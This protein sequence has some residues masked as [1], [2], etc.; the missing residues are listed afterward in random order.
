MSASRLLL[1]LFLSSL[2][3][4]ASCVRSGKTPGTSD[5]TAVKDSSLSGGAKLE[6]T[7]EL[8]R[9]A[10]HGNKGDSFAY[11]LT[12]FQDVT[13]TRDSSVEK[14]RQRMAYRYR[15]DVLETSD[16]G[17]SRLRVTCLGMKFKGEYSSNGES[18]TMQYDSGEKNDPAKDKQ[19]AQY[20]APVNAP[21]EIQLSKEGKIETVSKYEEVIKRL[22]GKE[23]NTIKQEA[24]QKI[25]NDFAE[26]GLKDIVQTAFQK[27]EDRP[28]G[29]DSAWHHLWAGDLGFMK[30][31]NDA[32]YTL[33]GFSKG[34][35]G[36][37]AHISAVMTSKY[38]GSKTLDTGQGMA[39][40]EDFDVKGSGATV[41]D[42]EKGRPDS[43]TLPQT[44][45][46]RFFIDPPA[47][48]K[49]AAPDQAKGFRITQNAT[50]ESTVEKIAL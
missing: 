41:F 49:Q 45:H 29:V 28:L 26:H 14:S 10:M 46:V 37:L 9:L 5:S 50:V 1:I 38:I 4:L 21:F 34:D 6:R 39:T 20:N 11:V 3:A 13:M 24:R 15:F 22:L 48:L 35:H 25:A 19:F 17:S 12:S 2:A 16:D 32:T 7:A 44:I 47:E 23:F 8:V 27:L 36:R 30:I 43:R 42:I 31:R 18:K 33:K 40:V